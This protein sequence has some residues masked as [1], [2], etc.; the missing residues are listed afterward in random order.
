MTIVTRLVLSTYIICFAT[1]GFAQEKSQDKTQDKTLVTVNGEVIKES[2]LASFKRNRPDMAQRGDDVLVKE[3]IGIEL[4]AQH[5]K[6]NGLDKRPE[7]ISDIEGQIRAILANAMIQDYHSKNPVTDAEIRAD[8]D[9]RVQL[10]PK[11]QYKLKLLSTATEEDAKRFVSELDKGAKIPDLAKD[12]ANL[13]QQ[14]DVA[15][16]TR[17]AMP[18]T[19]AAVVPSMVKGTYTKTPVKAESSW[20][21]MLFEDVRENSPP[22]AYDT[23]VNQVR[24]TIQA[25]RLNAFIEQLSKSAKIQPNN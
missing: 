23:V 2:R 20:H 6:Q 5:A 17:E 13:A 16:M 21:V 25:A 1:A 12:P 8:Y 3:L 18:A 7:V 15:W 22:P 10:W 24:S 11:Q 14:F 4:L 19:V 9:K